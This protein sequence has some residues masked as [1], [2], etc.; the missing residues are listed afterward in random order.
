[1]T[2]KMVFIS[3]YFL[4]EIRG[5]AEYCNEALIGLLESKYEVLRAK[6]ATVTPAFIE[7]HEDSF[8]IVANFFQLSESSKQRLAPVP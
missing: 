3:D 6:S 8:F 5:G 7:T 1:M 2:S 4:D